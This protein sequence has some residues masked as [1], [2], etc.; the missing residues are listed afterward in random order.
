MISTITQKKNIPWEYIFIKAKLFSFVCHELA[1]MVSHNIQ[2]VVFYLILSICSP[3]FTDES[4][5]PAL[6][7][8]PTGFDDEE[9]SF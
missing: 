2:T 8:T 4:T 6:T 9:E 1:V 5:E 3:P 7:Q